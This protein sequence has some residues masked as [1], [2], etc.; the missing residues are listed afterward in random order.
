MVADNKEIRMRETRTTRGKASGA[1]D[2][3]GTAA[4]SLQPDAQQAS[5][6]RPGDLQ[7]KHSWN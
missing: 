6:L 2:S 4:D 5:W 7:R 1:P 3:L